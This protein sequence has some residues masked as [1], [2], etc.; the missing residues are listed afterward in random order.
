MLQP[1]A[2]IARGQPGAEPP[3]SPVLS[4]HPAARAPLPTPATD[5]VAHTGPGHDEFLATLTRQ[6]TQCRRY[7]Q[8]LAVLSVAIERVAPLEGPPAEG[9]ESAVAH[10]LWNRLRARTRAK[11]TVLRLAGAEFAVLLPGCRPQATPGARQRLAVALGGVYALGGGPV[12]ATLSVGAASLGPDGDHAA[13]LWRAASLAR[14]A[15]PVH[16]AATMRRT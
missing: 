12:M 3:A 11:D 15:G 9:Q 16:A 4:D 6:I 7:A 1:S 5:G 14:S 8:P 10:E 2:P 13:A